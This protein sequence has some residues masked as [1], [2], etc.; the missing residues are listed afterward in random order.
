LAVTSGL[1]DITSLVPLKAAANAFTGLNSD[2]VGRDMIEQASGTTPAAGKL[3][4]YANTDHSFHQVNS[5]GTDTPLGGSATQIVGANGLPAAK[6]VTPTSAINWVQLSGSITNSAVVVQPE[7]AD[8]V[9][10]MHLNYKGAG[11]MAMGST[12]N[13]STS[14]VIQI[15][16][17][18]AGFAGM[19]FDL[20]DPLQIRGGGG[21]G[22]TML[23][24]DPATGI[25]T[26]KAPQ[27]SVVAVASL[28][29]CTG[30]TEGLLY[31]VND[32]AA[33]PVYNAIVAGGGSV[34]I[35]VYCNGTNWVNH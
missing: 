15:L 8:S 33:T 32:A 28:P 14:N 10:S 1:L 11:A 19:Y 35:P 31:A 2:A 26:I 5:S 27:V 4:I 25:T 16:D 20:A 17:H 6:G 9:I 21:L 23:Q 7:G 29:A 18:S 22:A 12:A 30:G 13:T 34:H 3:H 24:V